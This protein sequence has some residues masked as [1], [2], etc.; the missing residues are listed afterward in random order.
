MVLGIQ[1]Q[2]DRTDKFASVISIL[3]GK[4][5]KYCIFIQLSICDSELTEFKKENRD[6]C[7]FL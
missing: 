1:S 6:S 4:K 7:N 2:N 5:K 3:Q